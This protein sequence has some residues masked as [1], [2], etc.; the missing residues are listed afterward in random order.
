MGNVITNL[1]AKF[2]VETSDFKK[3]LKDGEK[4]M[5]E[6]KEA[7]GDK[8]SEFSSLFGVN[9]SGVT[10]AVSLASKSL[11]YLKQSFVGAA[12]GGDTLAISMK[13]LKWLFASTGI[14]ALILVLSSLVTYFTKTTAGA[15]ELAVGMGQLKAAGTVLMERLGKYGGGVW[16]MLK[17]NFSEGYKKMSQAMYGLADATSKA[18]AQGK[19]LAE[20]NRDIIRQEREFNVIKSEQWAKLEDLRL[21]SRDIDLSAK[22][23]FAA[24]MAAAAI[25]KKLDQEALRLAAEKILNAQTALQI[26]TQDRDKKDALAEAYINYNN[27]VSESFQWERSLTRQKNSLIKEMRDE[28][29]ALQ[30]LAAAFEAEKKAN[31]ITKVEAKYNPG[32]LEGLQQSQIQTLGAV[33]NELQDMYNITEQSVENLATGFADWVGAF[34]SGLAG[35]RDMRQM[36]GFAF[37]D[38]LIALGNVAIKAGI[39][40]EA[41]KAAFAS[42]GGVASIAIGMGLVAFGSS[43][44]GSIAQI[45]DARSAMAYGGTSSS[46]SSG[47]SAVAGQLSSVNPTKLTLD[48]TVLLK[49]TGSDLV[50]LLNNENARINIAT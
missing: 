24:L 48:G 2:G 7:A 25:E 32:T 45:N 8:I 10:S 44:K 37:G 12:A 13:A 28:E 43:I 9:M 41:I 3:G 17:G 23:R 20:S 50:A 29:K 11:G 33:S 5:S 6:F 47:G 27:I 16:D 14:G 21:Q 26:D 40:I 1:K 30:D 38:M 35:F 19:L 36:V 4:A 15:K 46:Y 42:M 18:A 39:G 22:E 31:L 49:L 34:S